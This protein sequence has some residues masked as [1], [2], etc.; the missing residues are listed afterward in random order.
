MAF[1]LE[2]LSSHSAGS[3]TATCGFVICAFDIR[4]GIRSLHLAGSLW[5]ES[6]QMMSESS[7]RFGQQQQVASRCLDFL[8][9][10]TMVFRV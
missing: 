9:Y 1:G 4:R 3:N 10:A 8:D 7:R 5:I 6:F 2:G